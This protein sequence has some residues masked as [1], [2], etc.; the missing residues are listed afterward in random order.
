MADPPRRAGHLAV[1]SD[2]LGS[3]KLFLAIAAKPTTA[4]LHSRRTRIL[5]DRRPRRDPPPLQ[6]DCSPAH[7]V[8]L[9]CGS[10]P[11]P[12]ARREDAIS[13]AVG[14]VHLC[15]IELRLSLHP[16]LGSD[17]SLQPSLRVLAAPQ[18]CFAHSSF[19]L[20]TPDIAA[21]ANACSA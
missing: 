8:S 9:P 18:R 6:G 15:S 3:T 13:N 1:A 14:G 17:R 20:F 19:S 2:P 12:H 16:F 7:S 10:Q 4:R 11:N 21:V 5:D